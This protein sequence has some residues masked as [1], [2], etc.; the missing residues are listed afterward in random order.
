MRVGLGQG[1][2]EFSKAV[3]VKLML[4]HFFHCQVN[5]VIVGKVCLDDAV[6]AGNRKDYE[7]TVHCEGCL[8]RS[9]LWKTSAGIPGDCR[10]LPAEK[11]TRLC[12][13]GLQPPESLCPALESSCGCPP[14][15]SSSRAAARLKELVVFQQYGDC[16][17]LESK[18]YLIQMAKQAKYLSSKPSYEWVPHCQTL[19]SGPCFFSL[20]KKY[21]WNFCPN[22]IKQFKIHPLESQQ[23]T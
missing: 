3:H 2:P 11:L 10:C 19:L 6:Y 20:K 4:R 9:N 15:I 23:T 18:M 21:Q 22:S 7:P 8:S 1:T 16:E 5:E 14:L 12:H 17:S 13:S